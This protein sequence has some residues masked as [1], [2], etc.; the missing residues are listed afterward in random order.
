MVYVHCNYDLVEAQQTIADAQ[1]AINMISIPPCFVAL[2]A[3]SFCTLTILIELC[4]MVFLFIFKYSP[5]LPVRVMRG[6]Q[7]VAIF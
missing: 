4:G 6:G 5:G 1:N 3:L 2:D 7:W